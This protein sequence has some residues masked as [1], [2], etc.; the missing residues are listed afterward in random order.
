MRNS[1]EPFDE[2]VSLDFRHD[3]RRVEALGQ[4]AARGPAVSARGCEHGRHDRLDLSL[5]RLP[6]GAQ[7]AEHDRLDDHHDLFRV[8]V[9]CADLR[10]LIG[11]EK[12]FE[13]SPENRRVD[14]APIEA[15][16]GE[17]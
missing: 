12:A 7:G 8:G 4:I 15:R 10:A 16:S 2:R 6:L 14:E 13:Q 3:A 9:V 5:C 1:A 17:Q 11:I